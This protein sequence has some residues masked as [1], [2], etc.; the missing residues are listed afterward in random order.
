LPDIV[1]A[2][3]PEGIDEEARLGG[4]GEIGG[5][6]RGK[7]AR[8]EAEVVCDLFHQTA[9]AGRSEINRPPLCLGVLDEVE[10]RGIIG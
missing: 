7:P 9:V 10:N 3:L 8:E 1:E 6:V 4:T 2:A 5:L